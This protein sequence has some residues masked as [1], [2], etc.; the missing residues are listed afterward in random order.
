MRKKTSYMTARVPLLF[1]L[2]SEKKRRRKHIKVYKSKARPLEWIIWL[3]GKEARIVDMSA[4]SESLLSSF[5]FPSQ[6]DLDSTKS[7]A[8]VRRRRVFIFI[9]QPDASGIRLSLSLSFPPSKRA[10]PLASFW[11]DTF[12]HDAAACVRLQKLTNEE[13]ANNCNC[14]RCLVRNISVI[15]IYSFPFWTTR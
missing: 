4:P 10:C 11:Y 6:M 5:S 3:G 12:A 2:V 14:W 7:S 1:Q 8:C 13:I 9:L 15:I